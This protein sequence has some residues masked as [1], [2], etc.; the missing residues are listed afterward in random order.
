MN[1]SIIYT[2]AFRFPNGDAAS[3]R[4]LNNAKIFRDLGYTVEFISWGGA[5]RHEDK[6]EDG[7]Y[8]Y[9]GF[10]YSNTEDIDKLGL[11]VYFRIYNFFHRG[12]NSLSLISNQI[13]KTNIVIA[14]NPSSYFTRKLLKISERHKVSFLTDITE[15]YDSNEFPGSRF[16]PP[17]WE[18]DFNMKII[19]KQV[20]DK[21]VIS[22]FLDSYYHSSNNLKLPP[23]VDLAENKWSNFEINL[24]MFDGVRLIYA[25]TPAKK[26]LL[27][28]I[29]NAFVLC[30]K[31]GLKVQLIVIGV[32]KENLSQYANVD[33]IL[34]IP[35]NIIFCGII[36]HEKVITYYKNS[37]FSIIIREKTRKSM[38]G[39]PTKFVESMSA[40]VPVIANNTSDIDKYITNGENGFIVEDI[41]VDSLYNVLYKL[42]KL[43]IEEINQMK[44]NAYKTSSICF[45][46]RNYITKTQMFLNKL[47]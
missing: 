27:N 24:P 42:N 26:D 45:D 17:S 21:I 33:E 15:W 4:V 44:I 8:Y 25:G 6:C 22:S 7:L 28:V 19:Q 1:K 38:A 36:P 14:Y 29:L 23:L 37:D 5:A 43:S 41:S 35:Y 2:G 31:K 16:F 9:Q 40:S 11:G 3:I 34:S 39:F 47:S 46:Y 30:V 32:S 13:S 12:Q 20:K 10:K 18:N